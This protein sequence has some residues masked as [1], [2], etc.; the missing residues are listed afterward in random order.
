MKGFFLGLS[1]V[2][3]A[4]KRHSRGYRRKVAQGVTLKNG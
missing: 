4:Q 3:V 1:G 2:A